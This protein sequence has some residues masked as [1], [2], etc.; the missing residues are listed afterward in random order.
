L[1]VLEKTAPNILLRLAALLQKP[2]HGP[3]A[4]PATKVLAL[5]T[6]EAA[7]ALG[8]DQEIGSLEVGKRADL[9]LLDLED[10][11]SLPGDDIYGRVVYSA[12]REQVRHVLVNGGFLVRDGE[13]VSYDRRELAH[14]VRKESRRLLEKVA[15]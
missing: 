1:Q 12:G 11:V 4:M 5:Q 2:V 6:S 3:T 7:R 14:E 9:V 10:L 8:M 13:L 15:G